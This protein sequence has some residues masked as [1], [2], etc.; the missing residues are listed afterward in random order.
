G[1]AVAASSSSV[2]TTSANNPK[3]LQRRERNRIESPYSERM[4]GTRSVERLREA[5]IRTSGHGP[6]RSGCQGFQDYR[7]ATQFPL[8]DTQARHVSG[9]CKISKKQLDV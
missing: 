9:E 1:T 7:R 5:R 3:K 4:M 8:T 2:G 6:T